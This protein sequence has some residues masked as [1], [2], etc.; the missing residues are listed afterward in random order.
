[1]E[2]S[3]KDMAWTFIPLLLL[4]MIAVGSYTLYQKRTAYEQPL[5]I[6]LPEPTAA[7]G[8]YRVYVGGAVKNPGFYNATATGGL[9]DL[10]QDAGGP[11]GD[12]DLSNINLTIPTSAEKPQPQKININTAEMWLLEAL[13]QVGKST[14]QEIINYRTKNGP[15][16]TVQE[17]LKIKGIGPK[18]FEQIK[19]LITVN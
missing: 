17:L 2:S 13:P 9:Q 3:R 8:T 1:M 11:A 6:R 14:A 16:N 12:A 10:I 15:F 18:K 19:D 4:V 7:A 5:A